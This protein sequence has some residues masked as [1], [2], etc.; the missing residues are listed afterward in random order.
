MASQM[1]TVAI[2]GTGVAINAAYT[3]EQKGDPFPVMLGGGLFTGACLA[4]GGINARLGTVVAALF[5]LGSAL[6]HG[7][8]VLGM[9]SA[10]AN[11]P[12]A[13]AAKAKAKAKAPSKTKAKGH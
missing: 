3:L 10:A 4:I 7:T 9:V 8:V 13:T 6:Y 11:S 5:L 12:A 1:G 2:V